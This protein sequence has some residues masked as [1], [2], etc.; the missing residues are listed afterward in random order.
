MKLFQIFKNLRI[1]YKLLLAYFIVPLIFIFGIGYVSYLSST[2]ALKKQSYD[3]IHQ[4]QRNTIAEIMKNLSRYELIANTIYSNTKIQQLMS[5]KNIGSYLEY[6]IVR[7]VLN[8]TLQSIL[9][10]SGGGL[11]IQL[12]RY[13][14]YNSEIIQDNVEG[15]LR[16]RHISD[17]YLSNESR[18]FQVINFYRVMDLLWFQQAKDNID[19]YMWTQ[20]GYDEQYNYISLLHEITDEVA[21]TLHTVAMLRLTIAFDAIHSEDMG[22]QENVFNLVVNQHGDLLSVESGK[23][24]FFQK[25]EE[26]LKTFIHGSDSEKLLS[27]QGIIMVKSQPFSEGWHIISIYPVRYITENVNQIREMTIITIVSSGCLLF[28]MTFF[29]SGSFSKRIIRIARQIQQFS[30]GSH[31]TEITGAGQDEIEFLGNTFTNMEQQISSLIHDNYQSNIDKKDALLKALQAQINPHFLYNSMSAIARLAEQGET[32]E[33]VSMVHALTAFY[34]MT[35]NKG[36]ET[37]TVSDEL[38]QVKAYLEVFGIRKGESF[39]VTYDL[40]ENALQYYTIKVILQPFIENIFEHAMNYDESVVNITISI[41][42]K[43]DCI[44]FTI[45]DD[46]LGIPEEKME[47]LFTPGDKEGYGIQNVNERI[48]LQ[49]GEGYGVRI[50]SEFGYGTTVIILIPKLLQ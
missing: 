20:V 24:G 2:D 34:R 29:L 50:K 48:K 32:S 6:E 46:G 3:L 9:D 22:N 36:H 19:G 31:N 1:K 25:N 37:I 28:I 44:L 7:N 16:H 41:H 47:T 11:N 40:D 38:A 30:P 10:A 4:Y 45:E 18:Q 26:I 14:N 35:L 15:I 23:V 13:S 8:P 12:I 5:D 17:F 43:D 42:L 39:T 49:F 21:F 27:D 33:I